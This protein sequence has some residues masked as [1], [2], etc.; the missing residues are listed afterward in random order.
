[1]NQYF[2]VEALAVAEWRLLLIF[3]SMPCR[4]CSLKSSNW[5]A[6]MA[7]SVRWPSTFAFSRFSDFFIVQFHFF[8]LNHANA[9]EFCE[10]A[11]L[12][13][14]YDESV[15][16]LTSPGNMPKPVKR[17]AYYSRTDFIVWGWYL[18][19]AAL[20]RYSC[21][22][23]QVRWQS[24]DWIFVTLGDMEFCLTH[25]VTLVGMY[26]LWTLPVAYTRFHRLLGYLYFF[27]AV[28]KATWHV[29]FDVVEFDIIN[30]VLKLETNFSSSSFMKWEQ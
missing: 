29:E 25:L 5:C 2:Y 27:Y 18:L 14:G 24:C 22:E 21:F 11:L 23:I 28:R 19:V 26:G 15:S 17:L 4:R 3:F 7:A 6:L 9:K 16:R 13:V 12:T 30:T 8:L 20:H 10:A 1:M